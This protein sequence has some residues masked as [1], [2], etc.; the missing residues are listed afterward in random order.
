MSTREFQIFKFL[1]IEFIGASSS[2]VSVP[3]ISPQGQRTHVLQPGLPVPA[4]EANLVRFYVKFYFFIPQ[5]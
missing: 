4:F 5:R 3:P 1:F 2:R